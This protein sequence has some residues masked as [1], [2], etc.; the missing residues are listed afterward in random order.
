MKFTSFFEIKQ[1]RK[2]LYM[3]NMNQRVKPPICIL[4][5]AKKA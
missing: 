2:K 4:I 1:T 5:L 3:R